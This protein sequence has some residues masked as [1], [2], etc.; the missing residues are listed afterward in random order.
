MN[1]FTHTAGYGD[2]LVKETKDVLTLEEIK[3]RNDEWDMKWLEREIKKIKD[4]LFCESRKTTYNR[5]LKEYNELRK[6][7]GKKPHRNWKHI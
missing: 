5:M 2:K 4:N 1:Y 3:V 7:Y 6:K